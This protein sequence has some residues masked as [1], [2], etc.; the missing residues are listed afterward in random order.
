MR[1]LKLYIKLLCNKKTP[2]FT[3]GFLFNLRLDG[4]H[5]YCLLQE[6]L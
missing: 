2:V 4:V 3:G 5:P 6:F 1:N